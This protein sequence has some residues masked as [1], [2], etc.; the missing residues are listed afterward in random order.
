[1]A[2]M[3]NT[4]WYGKIDS[5]ISV[6]F[7]HLNPGDNEW[8]TY[9]GTRFKID[10]EGKCGLPKNKLWSDFPA[11]RIYCMNTN[12][13]DENMYLFNEDEGTPLQN[14]LTVYDVYYEFVKDIILMRG[15]T[16]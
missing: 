10:S 13:G 2:Q 14:E 3:N 6:E 5:D 8:D 9:A 4:P 7:R 16:I 1:M 12:F 15:R 11:L